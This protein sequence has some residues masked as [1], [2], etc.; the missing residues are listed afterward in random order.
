VAEV[1]EVAA[2]VGGIIAV[3]QIAE[4]ETR[5]THAPQITAK[6]LRVL[7]ETTE[8]GAIIGTVGVE[9]IRISNQHIHRDPLTRRLSNNSMEV[10]E[11]T[12]VAGLPEDDHHRI[13]VVM[14]LA[15]VDLLREAVLLI[16]AL[17]MDK[18]DTAGMERLII[19][20]IAVVIVIMVDMALIT[21]MGTK[22]EVE[23]VHHTMPR[24]V[25]EAGLGSYICIMLYFM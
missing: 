6:T 7:T 20:D 1:V 17:R 10:M 12:V 15:V 5:F 23:E 21:D 22:V 16:M 13:M 11:V 4:G 24:L 9:A 8:T 14:D 25:G 18:V 2:G 19:M 3:H